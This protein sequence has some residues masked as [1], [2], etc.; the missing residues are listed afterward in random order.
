MSASDRGDA[1]ARVIV[2]AI[3]DLMLATRVA[4]AARAA[5]ITLVTTTLPE[6]VERC[7]THAPERVLIDLAAPGD[8]IAALAALRAEP[9]LTAVPVVGC[10]PHVRD[11]LRVAALAAGATFAIPRSAFTSQLAQVLAGTFPAAR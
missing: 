9:K 11:E 2:A 5:G 8:P 1:P 4:E 10:Y 7:R 6:L 3:P